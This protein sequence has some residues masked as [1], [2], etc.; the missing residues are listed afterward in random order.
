MKGPYDNPKMNAFMLLK[1]DVQ[2]IPWLKSLHKDTFYRDIEDSASIRG[3]N[4]KKI[5]NGQHRK[6][7]SNEE[8][9]ET[10]EYRKKL[11]ALDNEEDINDEFHELL[12]KTESPRKTS[13]QQQTYPYSMDDSTLLLPVFIAIRA[14][15][16]LLFCLCKL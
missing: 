9:T 3:A 2:R 1:R 14:F 16:P 15:I 10:G 7:V 12:S 6:L 8:D 11:P 4:K 13:G 5:L